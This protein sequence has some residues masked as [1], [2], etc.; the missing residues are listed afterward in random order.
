MERVLLGCMRVL[1]GL[2]VGLWV[3]AAQ[4]QPSAS[5]EQL[6]E[7]TEVSTPERQE[8]GAQPPGE[9]KASSAAELPPA[10]VPRP[11]QFE[12]SDSSHI[13]PSLPERAKAEFAGSPKSSSSLFLPPAL[14]VYGSEVPPG[15]A[16]QTRM[17]SGLF[18]G[19]LVTQLVF[20]GASLVYVSEYGTEQGRAWAVVPLV[21]P[22]V[23]LAQ[24]R[25]S[26][27]AW[28]QEPESSAGV[29][30]SLRDCERT[31]QGALEEVAFLSVLGVGQL[32]GTTLGL[33][34]ILDRKAL[35]VREDLLGARLELD[36]WQVGAG[37]GMQARG[38]F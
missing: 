6:P 28:E 7:E 8:Q 13:S 2:S 32:V 16:L 24:R 38:R 35:W 17:N 4:A 31:A 3:C 1:V 20:S 33:V 25:F 37:G 36:F 11:T 15:Y 23:A 9:E 34:G 12:L 18:W 27:D 22:W 5:F 26:C 10:E 19:G 14:P 30:Q 29:R 21:G